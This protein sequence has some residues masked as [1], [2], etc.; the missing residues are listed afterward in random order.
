MLR[1]IF[2]AVLIFGGNS[3]GF[4]HDLLRNFSIDK[5]FTDMNHGSYGAT[6]TEVL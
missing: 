5:N 2:I 6:P 4:G 1:V 3:L